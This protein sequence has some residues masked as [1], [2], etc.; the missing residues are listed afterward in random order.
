MHGRPRCCAYRPVDWCVVADCAGRWPDFRLPTDRADAQEALRETWRRAAKERVEVA[1]PGGY[2]RTGTALAGL[3]VLDGLSASE[4]V[5]FVRQRYNA[6]AVETPWQ[7]RYIEH[8]SAT[9]T[10][11]A[12]D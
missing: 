8:F 7:R 11:S 1:C 12:A 9:W 4:A 5:T 3:A 6:R 2:G 10:S